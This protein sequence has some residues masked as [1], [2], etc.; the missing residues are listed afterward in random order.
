M[1]KS[2]LASHDDLL[3]GQHACA[4]DETGQA[5]EVQSWTAPKV[6][7]VSWAKTC[8]SA[9]VLTTT[10]APATVSFRPPLLALAEAPGRQS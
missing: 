10:L 3:R 4:F 5:A 7:P 2:P 6:W 9:E 1:M 8:H